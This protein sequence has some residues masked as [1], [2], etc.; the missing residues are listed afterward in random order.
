[1]PAALR[2]FVLF[3]LGYFVSYVYRGVNLGFAPYLTHELGL[4]AADLGLLTSLYFLG[5]AGAQL[6]VGILLDRFG[7][8]RVTAVLILVAA[9]GSVVFGMA[10]SKSGLML[11]RLL[12][13]IGLAACLG[14]A[15]KALAQ[16]FDFK[17]LPLLNGL[18]MAIGGLGGVAMGS[19]L[20]WLLSITDWR[21]ICFGL[22]A[23][24]ALVALGIWFG[25]PKSREVAHEADFKS[26]LLGSWHVLKSPVFWKVAAFSSMTQ[27][28]FYAMQSL[29][30]APYLRDVSGLAPAQV[31]SVI[32]VLGVAMMVGSVGF[33]FLAR[34]LERHGISVRLFSGF[35]MLLFMLIQGLIMAQVAVPLWL[36]WA[37]Y[38]LVGGCGILSYAVLVEHF[39]IQLIGRV[40]TSLT[41]LIFVLIFLCQLGVGSVLSLWPAT[42]GHYP[43][44]AHLVAWGILLGLQV[45]TAVWYFFPKRKVI[46]LAVY[47]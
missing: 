33:G 35:G 43:A 7:S 30:M 28:V 13:G 10:T 1:M 41:L 6:P 18:T 3:A 42:D 36:L 38:G 25:V 29:W 45:M 39:P 34:S 44:V 24:S 4:S 32:S 19:P 47:G 2:V 37:A 27:G 5:F 31:G 21:S 20:L 12:I 17:R 40:N 15:F 16:W 26:Q 23:F 9:T 8:R 11:G 22:A 14:A 46:S